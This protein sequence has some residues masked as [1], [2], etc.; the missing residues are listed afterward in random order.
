M[1]QEYL[2]GPLPINNNEKTIL[3]YGFQAFSLGMESDRSG[4]FQGA[5]KG[6]EQQFNINQANHDFHL[7]YLS[8]ML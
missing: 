5:F 8:F 4:R 6:N 1:T 2:V 3:H 7:L